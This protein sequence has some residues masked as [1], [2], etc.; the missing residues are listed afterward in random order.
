VAGEARFPF[1]ENVE[2]ARIDILDR[3]GAVLGTAEVVVPAPPPPPEVPPP[4]PLP[5]I[6]VSA[7]LLTIAA[8]PSLVWWRPTPENTFALSLAGSGSKNDQAGDVSVRASGAIGR[9]GVNAAFGYPFL[10]E[11]AAGSA[12]W[13]GGQARV[14]RL[15]ASTL[16][17][18]FGLR[19]GIPV[20][21]EEPTRLEP[22]IAIGGAA[23]E[24]TWLGNAGARVRLSDSGGPSGVPQGQAFAMVG[25][26]FDPFPWLR[27]HA[28][29]DG[30]LLFDEAAK[31]PAA[32]GVTVGLETG[33]AFFGG[34]SLRVSPHNE[35]GQ[36]SAAGQI[37]VG[38]REE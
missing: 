23:G 37:A 30:S 15:E 6:G 13:L 4:A 18:G 34:V 19:V 20:A 16:E 24:I 32:A 7:P 11:N 22:S 27:T 38:F 2:R 29:L 33:G 8:G 1:P 17:L 14:L 12:A 9:F 35:E 3:R 5:R 26:T 28:E 36:R 31:S 21:G 10:V 25:A